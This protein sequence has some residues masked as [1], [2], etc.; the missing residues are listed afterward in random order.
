MREMIAEYLTDIKIESRQDFFEVVN[1]IAPILGYWGV[2]EPMSGRKIMQFTPAK[3]RAKSY[4]DFDIPKKSGGKRRISAPVKP[5]KAIQSVINIFLQ[6]IF[7]PSSAVTGFVVGKSIKDNAEKHIGQ[8]CIYNTDLENFFPS[9]T[10]LMIRKALKRELGHKISSAEVINIICRICTVPN[11]NGVEVL[12]Q[13]APTSPIL[14]NIVLKSMDEEMMRLAD[15][16]HCRYSRYA[17]DM[18]FSHRKQIRRMSKFWEDRILKIIDK[19]GLKVN[20]KKTKTYAPGTRMEVTGV[21]VTNKTN[22]SRQYIKQLRTLL[23]LW[24]KYGY[25]QAQAIYVKD[26]CHGVTKNLANVIDGK[27]NYLEMIKGK[28]DP[29][30]QKYKRRF[31]T[32][33]W[34]EKQ[35]KA[36]AI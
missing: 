29:T 26:F 23:H 25:S 35:L 4:I 6:S 22:V 31:K 5:L 15:R 27:I 32:L 19:Y 8:T 17:D 16:M 3:V 13:G 21:T 11:E 28:D 14:S 36:K 1:M 18:T 34:K 9:I 7:V 20:D 12:P 24:D 2:A 30:Y 10:K 33:E